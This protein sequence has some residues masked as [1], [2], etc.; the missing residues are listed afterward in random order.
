MKLCQ[1]MV[2]LD[3]NKM[4]FTQKVLGTGTGSPAKWPQQQA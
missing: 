2:R 3:I 4:Y 1:G